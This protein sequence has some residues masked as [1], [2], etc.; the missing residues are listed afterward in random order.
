[1]S[2]T[3]KVP[4]LNYGDIQSLYNDMEKHQKKMVDMTDLYKYL[5]NLKTING[6]EYDETRR[7]W[8][9]RETKKHM[10]HLGRNQ[11]LEIVLNRIIDIME[12]S[13]AESINPGEGLRQDTSW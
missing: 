3:P 13:R 12:R 11:A 1:M 9:G 5:N 10:L 7:G 6:Y 8:F 2:H 4:G